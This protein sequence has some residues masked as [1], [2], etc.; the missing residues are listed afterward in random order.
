MAGLFSIIPEIVSLPGDRVAQL[1]SMV[2]RQ[3]DLILIATRSQLSS[4]GAMRLY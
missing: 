2:C 4:F 3:L 1:G